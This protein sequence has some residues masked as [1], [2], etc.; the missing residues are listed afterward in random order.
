MTDGFCAERVASSA[1]KSV[2]RPETSFASG[3]RQSTFS[4]RLGSEEQRFADVLGLEIRIERENLL[5]RLSFGDQG[6]DCRD[7]NPKSAQARYS[8]HL[9]GVGRHSLEL[10]T[11]LL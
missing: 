1:P 6:H 7:W 2:C 5:R 8:S 11:A 3:E 4:D 9:A 10:H